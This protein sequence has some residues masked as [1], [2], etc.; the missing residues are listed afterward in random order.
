MC[1]LC[2]I[3]RGQASAAAASVGKMPG[4]PA[5]SRLTVASPFGCSAFNE[6]A[7]KVLAL[8][9]PVARWAERLRAHWDAPESTLL[10]RNSGTTMFVQSFC[11][12]GIQF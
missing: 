9:Y 7:A 8:G 10:A 3:V 11:L 6:W 1:H 12:L 5:L 2:S 4:L